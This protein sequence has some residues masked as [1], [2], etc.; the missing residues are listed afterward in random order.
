MWLSVSTSTQWDRASAVFPPAPLGRV[1]HAQCSVL[2]V[3]RNLI[4]ILSR[5]M[6]KIRRECSLG[7]IYN[8]KKQ[9][10]SHTVMAVDDIFG[11]CIGWL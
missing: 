5:V 3:N 1:Q 8:K 4:K 2:C 6:F 9:K 11:F 7:V 10:L